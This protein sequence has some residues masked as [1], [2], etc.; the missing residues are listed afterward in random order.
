MRPLTRLE[1]CLSRFLIAMLL[2]GILALVVLEYYVIY[3]DIH[4]LSTCKL[5]LTTLAF[6]QTDYIYHGILIL[7]SIYQL[8]LY[9]DALKQKNTFHLLA[10]ILYGLLFVVMTVVLVLQH[11]LFEQAECFESQ[12]NSQYTTI[13]ATRMKPFQYATL[14]LV[15]LLFCILFVVCVK[16][17]H[18][19]HWANYDHHIQENLMAWMVLAGLLKAQFYFLFI[20]AIQL[21]PAGMLDYDVWI[22]EGGVVLVFSLIVFLIVSFGIQKENGV[23]LG[24]FLIFVLTSLGYFGYRTYTFASPRST[25]KDV[26]ELTLNS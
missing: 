11:F 24:L 10:C 22:F 21:F 15:S 12:S 1:S 16:L 4:S 7:G 20:Y 19:F 2:L 5:T 3:Y 26:Y 14:A 25:N 17:Y 23:V 6:A 13:L 8:F 18:G 9:L